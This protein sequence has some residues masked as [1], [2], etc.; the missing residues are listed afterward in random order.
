M[1]NIM[2]WEFVAMKIMHR[3]DNKIVEILLCISFYFQHKDMLLLSEYIPY[4]FVVG[5]LFTK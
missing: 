2:Q 1:T 3:T 4:E 5:F